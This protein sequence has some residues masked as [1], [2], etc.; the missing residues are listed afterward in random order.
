KESE[1]KINEKS[2]TEVNGEL[3][4]FTPDDRSYPRSEETDA[5]LD[6]MA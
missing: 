1:N 5:E 4:E 3:M 6:H 2:I